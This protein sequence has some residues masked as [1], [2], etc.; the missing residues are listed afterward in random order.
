MIFNKRIVQY[1]FKVYVLWI[2]GFW[3]ANNTAVQHLLCNI[4]KG[5]GEMHIH[6]NILIMKVLVVH[7]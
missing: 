4:C 2:T 7:S 6:I 1:N 3:I 5:Y